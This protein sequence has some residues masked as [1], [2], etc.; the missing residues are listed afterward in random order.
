MREDAKQGIDK[1]KVSASE[2]KGAEVTAANIDRLVTVEC[3]LASATD[4]GTVVPLYKS[5]CRRVGDKP[6]SLVA[7]QQLIGHIESGDRVLLICGFASYPMLPYGETDGPLGV[8]SL[9]RAISFGLD[10]I[11][12]VVTG[13]R[14]ME[15]LR[16]TVHAAGLNVVDYDLAK[17]ISSPHN[18]AATEVIFP[19]VDKDESQR[20]ASSIMDKYKPKV[21]IS[22]ETCGPNK[23]GVKHFGGGTNAEEREKMP[24]LEY[25]LYEANAK[26]V[27]TMAM[28]DRGNEL[29][30]GTIE[31]DVRR[32][33]P[34]A[35]ICQ[36]PCGAGAACEVKADIIFPASIS[37]WGAYAITAMVGYLLKKPD[38]LQDPDTERRMLESCILA[39][40]VDVDGVMGGPL[41]SVDGVG[42]KAHESVVNILSSIVQNAL[43]SIRGDQTKQT[44]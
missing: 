44:V 20:L 13:P 30:S 10:A 32:I 21:I 18:A 9:A 8:A 2:E 39:G 24:A 4:R 40:A 16:R 33:V 12:V 23:K 34:Y 6:I 3:R 22:V 37:N 11:P 41:M 5:A 36:C 43:S 1:S 7:A 27:L 38:I 35:D 17:E 31:E 14:D 15:S 25:L 28:I 19:C 42:Y 26:K 29:G